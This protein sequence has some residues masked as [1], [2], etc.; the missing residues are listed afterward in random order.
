M[1]ASQPKFPVSSR[2][3]VQVG[4]PYLKIS[5][6]I[7]LHFVRIKIALDVEYS[8]VIESSGHLVFN[9]LAQAPLAP[10]LKTRASLRPMLGI[11]VGIREIELK[12]AAPAARGH[13]IAL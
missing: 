12:I 1:L 9:C 8:V 3:H 13:L 10:E 11:R 2:R 4:F 5:T 6:P 7:I